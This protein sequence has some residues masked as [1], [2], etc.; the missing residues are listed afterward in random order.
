MFRQGQLKKSVEY[1]QKAYDQE[2]EAEIAG[3]L[4]EVL[5]GLE[6][7]DEAR[8]VY[9]EALQ[10]FND[11]EYLLRLKQQIEGLSED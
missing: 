11:D 4:V 9:R 8:D 7:K 2:Q 10:K 3:H 1:L 6:R 5:W